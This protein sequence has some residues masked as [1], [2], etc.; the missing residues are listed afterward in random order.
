[1][2]INRGDVHGHIVAEQLEGIGAGHE[3][4]FAIDFDDHADFAAG[5]NVVADEAFG[6]FARGLFGRGGLAF[7]A[8]DV[9]G[10][11]NVAGGFHQSGAAITETSGREFSQFLD[12]LGWNFHN[13]F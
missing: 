8:K 10:L 6:G 7:L 1:V 13:W 12:E 2:T 4:A 11:L 5:M 3:I 9:N